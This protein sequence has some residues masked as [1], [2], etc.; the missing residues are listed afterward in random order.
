MLNDMMSQAMRLMEEFIK[1]CHQLAPLKFCLFDF[2][3]IK[4][5]E[6]YVDYGIY[7]KTFSVIDVAINL[8]RKKIN[9]VIIF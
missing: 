8:A 1:L 5:H 3:M 9:N 7:I 6:V 4:H 2:A